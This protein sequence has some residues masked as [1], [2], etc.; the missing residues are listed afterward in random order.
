[1][2]RLVLITVLL[3]GVTAVTATAFLGYQKTQSTP[4]NWLSSGAPTPLPG[5]VTVPVSRGDVAQ[6][7]TAPGQLVG[8][9]SAY[10]GWM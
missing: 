8:T 10:W 4:A 1:M 2:R 6:T 3:L 5:P 9:R 7:V